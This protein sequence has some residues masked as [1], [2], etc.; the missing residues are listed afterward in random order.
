MWRVA[1][2]TNVVLDCCVFD[3]PAVQP[4]KVALATGRAV[5]VRSLATDAELEEVLARPQFGLGRVA[6]RR[7]LD[8]WQAH[9]VLVDVTST[10]PFRCADPA[11]QKFLD[12]ALG[13]CAHVLF[14]KDK[15]L[16]ATA[17]RAKAHGLMVLPPRAADSVLL[18]EDDVA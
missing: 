14:T 16:L 18:F 13:A 5:A 12:L 17:T 6:R 1:L 2:D 10:A 9:A 15:A 7:L 11:D 3:D 8:H 4:L